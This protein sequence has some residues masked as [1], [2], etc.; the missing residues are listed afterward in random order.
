MPT[1]LNS[2]DPHSLN[3]QS[4]A[5]FLDFD[6]TLVD[7][8]VQPDLVEMPDGTLAAITALYEAL[9]GAIAVV[10]GREIADIDRFL[11]PLNLPVAGV[12][13]LHR[14]G[15][16]GVLHSVNS[17]A[18]EVAEIVS[19]LRRFVDSND[20]LQLEQK[21][22]SV[23]LHFRASP[24]LEAECH[25]V[26]ERVTGDLVQYQLLRGKM[27]IEAKPSC[28]NKGLAIKAFMAEA[29]FV[30]RSPFFAGDDVTDEDAFCFVNECGGI[31]VKVGPGETKAKFR[32]QSIGEFGDWLA[33]TAGHW[34]GRNEVE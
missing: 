22:G 27:V 24:H 30:G 9:G 26:M 14:R 3:A 32:A 20:G 2:L 17:D 13:G 1:Y 8:A 28:Y 31:S 16:D 5:M 7:F 10:S 29:P 19:R 11:S 25:E 4:T 23:A 33:K 15:H 18:R 21:A 12:H 6:G 34:A